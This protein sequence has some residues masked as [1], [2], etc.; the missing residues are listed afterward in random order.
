MATAIVILLLVAFGWIE[1]RRL[2]L[3]SMQRDLIALCTL[4]V[5]TLGWFLLYITGNEYANPRVWIDA[6]FEWMIP[7]I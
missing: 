1:G 5:V 3:E 2:Q 7:I 6:L 4:L